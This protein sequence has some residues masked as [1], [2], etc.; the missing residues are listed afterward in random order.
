VSNTVAK[1]QKVSLYEFGSSCAAAIDFAAIGSPYSGTTVGQPNDVSPSC[2]TSDS[3][4]GEQIFFLDVPP[5]KF[6]FT[7]LH[8]STLARVLLT[9][10][11]PVFEWCMQA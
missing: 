1:E 7:S 10:T 11:S 8:A 9:C 5:G 6:L 3:D 4:A 2:Y